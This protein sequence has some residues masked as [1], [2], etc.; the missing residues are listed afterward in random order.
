M[1]D[2]PKPDGGV[3]FDS[4]KEARHYHELLPRLRAGE[5]SNLERQRRFRFYLTD[6]KGER[7]LLCTY[8]ADFTY[9]LKGELVVE[10]VKSAMTKKLREYQLKK[11]LLLILYGIEVREV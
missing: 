1:K 6:Q 7:V 3:L 10:D 8:V 9:I 2:A 11:K 4:R 5:I